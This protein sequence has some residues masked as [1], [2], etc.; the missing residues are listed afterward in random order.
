MQGAALLFEYKSKYQ[1]E[2]IKLARSSSVIN[3]GITGSL[4]M[5]I[6]YFQNHVNM[7]IFVTTFLI[8]RSY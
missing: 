7:T 8:K 4:G 1:Y 2:S 3:M 5:H 6:P